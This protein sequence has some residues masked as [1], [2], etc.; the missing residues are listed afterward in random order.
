MSFSD[1]MTGQGMCNT[2]VLSFQSEL[3]SCTDSSAEDMLMDTQRAAPVWDTTHEL[4]DRIEQKIGITQTCNFDV[5]NLNQWHLCVPLQS[6]AYRVTGH[7]CALICMRQGDV[8]QQS[9]CMVCSSDHFA[10]GDKMAC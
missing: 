4:T 8:Q 5:S 9:L 10:S 6:G 2:A 7:N 3:H 1:T